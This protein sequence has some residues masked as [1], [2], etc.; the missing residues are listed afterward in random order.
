M[1]RTP[2]RAVAQPSRLVLLGP[3]GVGKGTQAQLLSAHT[4]ACALSTGDIFR[5][6]K[7]GTVEHPSPAMRTAVACMNRGELVADD[8]VLSLVHE[9]IRCLTCRGGFLL[10]GFPRTVAQAEAL[11]QLLQ[12]ERLHLDAALCYELPAETILARLTGRRTCRI[13]KAAFHITHHPPK[14]PGFCDHC[15]AP[16]VLRADD[17]PDAGRVRMAAFLKSTAP[18]IS[19]YRGHGRIRMIDASGTP[20]DVFRRTLATLHPTVATR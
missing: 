16:L 11:D 13:C 8:I 10:D 1:C 18:L 17:E 9:R 3:P 5:I 14:I 6:A 2:P 20:D 19:Y 7:S 4:G 12:Q 15:G